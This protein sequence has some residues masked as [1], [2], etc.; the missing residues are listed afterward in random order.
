MNSGNNDKKGL[1]ENVLETLREKFPAHFATLPFQCPPTDS[2]PQDRLVY[3]LCASETT[4]CESDFIPT[5]LEDNKSIIRK[6][7]ASSYSISF[8]ETMDGINRIRVFPKQR[9]KRAVQGTIKKKYGFMLQKKNNPHCEL[10]A[11][12]DATPWEDFEE[13][14]IF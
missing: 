7:D 5:Y 2:F 9:S 4:L 8:M 3:R 11:Y 6:N 13:K 10:W 1:S 12:C 14:E